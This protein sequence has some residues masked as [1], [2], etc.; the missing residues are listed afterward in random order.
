MHGH[1]FFVL[2]EGPGTWD[3]TVT[4]PSNP[5]RR[6]V[7]MLPSGHHLAIQI[8]AD[9]PGAWPLRKSNFPLDLAHYRIVELL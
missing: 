9:N 7:Q 2:S 5:Q 3:G 8:T 4:N 1:N 6:D